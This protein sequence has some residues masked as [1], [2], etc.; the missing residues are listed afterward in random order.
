MPRRSDGPPLGRPS[1]AASAPGGDG[2]ES[3]GPGAPPYTRGGAAAAAG[4]KKEATDGGG[5]P[6]DNGA[7]AGASASSASRVRLSP[8]IAA[9]VTL[10][11]LTVSQMILSTGP[12]GNT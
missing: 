1:V 8:E 5:G 7:A 3:D 4:P 9:E 10:S 2:A 12:P 11:F 6:N